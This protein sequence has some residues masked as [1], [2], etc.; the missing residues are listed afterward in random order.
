MLN[1][2]LENKKIARLSTASHIQSKKTPLTIKGKKKKQSFYNLND[3]D[4]KVINHW[5]F[6]I[7]AILRMVNCLSILTDK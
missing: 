2:L 1:K 7:E 3:L 6:P 5:I 4:L